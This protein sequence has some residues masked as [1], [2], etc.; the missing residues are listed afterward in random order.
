MIAG[1]VLALTRERDIHKG[2]T[3]KYFGSLMILIY[4]SL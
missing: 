4:S 1:I 2:S 3:R